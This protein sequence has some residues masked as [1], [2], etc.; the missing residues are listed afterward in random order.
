MSFFNF[1]MARS[2]ATSNKRIYCLIALFIVFQSV[3]IFEPAF[4]YPNESYQQIVSRVS[5]NI[6]QSMDITNNTNMSYSQKL[7]LT[8]CHYQW[9][10]HIIIDDIFSMWQQLFNAIILD[11]CDIDL[12]Y[13]TKLI[14]ETDK[15][16][17]HILQTNN[18]LSIKAESK[19]YEYA[20]H[21][22][23]SILYKIQDHQYLILVYYVL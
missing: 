4:V 22:L 7:D 6:I 5:K 16:L 8:K 19:D 15:F 23:I 14:F 18:P 13:L 2:R 21:D 17:Q 1:N 9:N 12:P 11:Q 10:E 20:Y 3:V